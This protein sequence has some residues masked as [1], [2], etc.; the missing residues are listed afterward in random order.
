MSHMLTAALEYAAQ[1]WAV[2]PLQPGTKVPYPGTQGF[3]DATTVGHVIQVLWGDNPNANI[4]IATGAVSGIVVLDFDEK[5]GGLDTHYKLAARLPETLICRTGGGGLHL[6][7][8]HPGVPIRN[9]AKLYPGMDVRGD[10]G[11]VVAPPSTTASLYE[12]QHPV[13]DSRP[14]E[15]AEMPA[16]LIQ[17]LREPARVAPPAHTADVDDVVEGGRNDYLA[18]VAGALQ[19]KGLSFEALSAALHAENEAK[20]VPPLPGYEVEMIARSI[21]RY[22]PAAPISLEM[23]LE[24]EDVEQE[25]PVETGKPGAPVALPAIEFLDDMFQGLEDD[26]RTK[27]RETPLAGLNEML[28]GGKRLGEL[29]VTLAEAK[30]GKSSLY[31]YFIHHWVNQSVGVGYASR[32]MRPGME[33]LP[34]LLSIEFQANV[35]KL[36]IEKKISTYEKSL[37]KETLTRWPLHFATGYGRFPINSLKRWVKELKAKGVLYFFIDHLHYCLEGV[38]DWAEAVDM[39]Q[40]LK[41]ITVTENVHIDLIVQPTKIQEGVK[42]GLNALRGGAGIGQA[43]DNLLILERVD[44]RQHVSKLTLDR[45]RWP[46]ANQGSH[47]L[48]QYNKDTRGFVEVEEEQVPSSQVVTAPVSLS[49]IVTPQRPRYDGS[50]HVLAA[51]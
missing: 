25:P 17:E 4:G 13:Q 22:T 28:G 3:K 41:E 37:Y 40:Q 10:G 2:F 5:A 36:G 20:C 38:E 49:K 21:S 44:G 35:L 18:R 34:N 43:L 11:Y 26:Q 24:G 42:L 7:F 8:K 29:T 23:A 31:A 15:P 30:T 6:Y 50:Q 39:A 27:G 12:W 14:L 51:T 45:A 33:V 1:G 46:L 47:I 9:K 16:W 48:I 19:R 32:E